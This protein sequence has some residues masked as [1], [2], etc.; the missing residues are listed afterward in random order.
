MTRHLGRSLVIAVILGWTFVPP[1]EGLGPQTRDVPDI[2]FFFE[3]VSEEKDA[4]EQALQQIG[5][6]WRDSYAALILDLARVFQ[7]RRDSLSMV[8]RLMGFLQEQTN[9]RFGNDLD[10]WREWVWSLPD[11][12]HPE[13]VLFKG[14]LYSAIDPRMRSFFPEDAPTR[15]RLDEVDWGG[16]GVNGIPPLNFPEHLSA[17]EAQ[18]LKDS[19]VVFGLSV[20]G[21]ARAYPKRILAWHEMARDRLGGLEITIVYCTLCGTA[22][23]YDNRLEGRVYRFGT[24]GLLYRS[25]KL[26]FDE[27][28]KSLWSSLEGKPVIGSLVG[29]G[30]RLRSLPVVT[31][32]WGEW[33]EEHPDTKV[34]SLDT[35]HERDYSEGAAYRDY[36]STDQLMFPVSKRDRRLKNKDEVLV[37]LPGTASDEKSQGMPLAISAKFL[38]KRRLYQTR[39][40]GQDIIVVTSREGANRVYGAQGERF[41][42]RVSDGR[43]EDDRGRIWRVTEEAL[44]LESDSETRLPRLSAQRAFWFGW[45]AQFPTTR[46]IK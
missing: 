19:N 35:G 18:Y 37:M 21:E 10:R 31:T 23:P 43:I 14:I 32:T 17:S 12:P 5:S 44:V 33:K 36:F 45:Y 4:S 9:Q 7:V 25:N 3:A 24:S 28:S 8:Q 34:L 30:L 13:C 27:E 41:E 11:E 2:E 42:R 1:A 40:A 46:L 29:S 22:I 20:N 6:M 26:M 39:T 16:V 38:K 15:I